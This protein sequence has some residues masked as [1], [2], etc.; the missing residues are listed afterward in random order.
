MCRL[1]ALAGS[2]GV[3]VSAPRV[4]PHLYELPR[5][6][7]IRIA[8]TTPS[9]SRARWPCTMAAGAPVN[10][11]KK[12]RLMLVNQLKIL[13]ALNP[14]DADFYRHSRVALEAGYELH[15]AN[16]FEPFEEPMSPDECREVQDVLEMFSQMKSA[17]ERLGKAKGAKKSDV[18]FRGFNASV[19]ARQLGYTRYLVDELGRYNELPDKRNLGFE[20]EA[21]MLQ[22]YRRMVAAWKG[23]DDRVR[24]KLD[25]LALTQVLD[26]RGWIEEIEFEDD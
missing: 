13:E 11:D 10:L 23:L 5:A 6:P 25:R 24:F 17:F 4:L 16:L 21:P 22:T 2:A 26:A 8:V 18:R 1:R 20:S 3:S 12:Y 7:H 15:Y 19:E 14:K 9:H